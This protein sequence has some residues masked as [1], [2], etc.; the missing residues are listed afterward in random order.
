MEHIREIMQS[1][2]AELEQTR[3]IMEQGGETFSRR[4]WGEAKERAMLL[5][6]QLNAFEERSR[7]MVDNSNV[8]RRFKG[9]TFSNFDRAKQPKAYDICKKF[10]DGFQENTG[11]GIILVGDPGTGKT[12]LAAAITNY[13]TSELG[14]A[15]K[16]G[17]FVDILNDIKRSFHSDEDVVRELKK[18]PLLVIDDLGKERRSE[19][20]EMIL[21]D[22]INGRYEDYMPTIITTNLSPRQIEE[23][24]GEATFSRIF[25]MCVGVIVQGADVRKE[26][27]SWYG[28]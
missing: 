7:K 9:R 14:V 1:L 20:S 27:S 12:H 18:M 22:V 2:K 16:F 21:Y 19:W 15:V 17:N 23:R 13:I 24:F 5:E 28:K 10:A 4:E 6:Q 8:G 3:S 25:E 11:K 26:N